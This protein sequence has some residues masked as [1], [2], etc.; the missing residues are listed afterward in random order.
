MGFCP[1]CG[2]EN[3]DSAKFCKNCGTSLKPSNPIKEDYVA[4]GNDPTA[5]IILIIVQIQN[6]IIRI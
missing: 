3:N 1:N 6:Q 2:H 4:T 5:K